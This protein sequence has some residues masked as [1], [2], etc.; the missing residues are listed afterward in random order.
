MAV[1]TKTYGVGIIGTGRISGAHARAAQNVERARLVVASE[2]DA[3]RGRRFG[4]RWG[5]EVIEDYHQ[6]LERADVDIVCLTLPHWLHAP[7]GVA[8]ARAGKHILVEK[9]M[10]DTVEECDLMIEAARANKVKLLTGHT[11]QFLAPNVKAR[12]MIESGAVGDA[13][14]AT[15]EWYKAFALHTRPPWFLD[16]EKGGGMWLM[17]G[18][19]MID[20]LTFILNS[21]VESVKA[22][23]GT[24]YH[25]GQIKTDDCAMAYLLLENGIP[26]TIAHTGF[27][28]KQG[29]GIE[30]SGGVIEISCTEAM[31]KVVDRSRLYRTVPAERGGQWEEVPVERR[32][33]AAV[34]LQSLIESIE[35]NTPE[36]CT[37]E[38]ARH[39]VAVMTACEESSRTRREVIVRA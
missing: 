18:A 39:I 9:P 22:F 21:R 26:A 30:Q 14:M 27:K 16:R 28:D 31:L 38:Q 36:A 10:A 19:H 4:E 34:E 37:V 6:L 35:N 23:V 33:T 20:R 7:I 32:D 11:E 12:Q 13:V 2:I 5:C 29:A 3:E 24:R 17:N 1:A 15:D 8:A 25:T